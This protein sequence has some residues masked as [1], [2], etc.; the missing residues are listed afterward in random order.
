M[1]QVHPIHAKCIYQVENRVGVMWQMRCT[2]TSMA[3]CHGQEGVMSSKGDH[4]NWGK[5]RANLWKRRRAS[6]GGETLFGDHE[7]ATKR[8]NIRVWIGWMIGV[9]LVFVSLFSW[10]FLF[11]SAFSELCVRSKG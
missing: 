5:D 10:S 7:M 11:L 6:N 2:S 4:V 1:C 3:L 8:K 9:K